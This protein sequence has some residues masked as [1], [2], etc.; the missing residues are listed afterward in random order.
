[1]HDQA[2]ELRHL[3]RRSQKP[4]LT[5]GPAPPLVVCSGGK[6]GVGTSTLALNLAVAFAGQG[7]R[8]VLVDADL[9][10]GSAAPL[11]QTGEPG[12]VLDV[13]AGRRSLHETLHPGPAG[14]QFVPGAWAPDTL[15]EISEAA[16][17]RFIGSL[18]S[19]GLHAE[20]VLVDVGT[21]RSPFVQRFWQAADAVLV[22]STDDTAAIIDAYSAIKVLCT[23]DAGPIYTLINQAADS[24]GA[25]QSHHRLAEACR[26]FLG[27]EIIGLGA[28]P[29]DEHVRQA[30]RSGG[31]FLLSSPRSAAA[32]SVDRAAEMLWAR[33]TAAS[34]GTSAQPRRHAASPIAR[35]A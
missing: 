25:V 33:L 13:L 9:N 34:A 18:K 8:A 31:S 4:G 32:R 27:H 19:L 6:G 14:I 23:D 7:R 15:S 26:R 28:V 20:V 5:S 10:H 11:G 17:K 21:A 22:V 3:M 12:S 29:L 24:K 16:Q 1:M 35:S 30:A 2:D